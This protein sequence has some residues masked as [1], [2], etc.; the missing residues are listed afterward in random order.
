[1]VFTLW[2]LRLGMAPRL[3]CTSLWARAER[4]T[5]SPEGVTNW[6]SERRVTCSRLPSPSRT[7]TGNDSVC[8]STLPP[9]TPVVDIWICL[10]I[11]VRLKPLIKLASS[12]TCSHSLGAPALK[13]ARVWSTS[14]VCARILRTSSPSVRNVS[15]F[16][17]K[18]INSTGAL[19]GGPCSSLRTST[20]ASGKALSNCCC[21][22]GISSL[23]RSKSVTFTMACA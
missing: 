12:F 9:I 2:P 17:P 19:K 1:M 6:I 10:A 18:I 16:G 5:D 23:A 11:S 13:V 15:R 4:A 22:S 3:T 7:R 14:G 20:C 8:S 21:N